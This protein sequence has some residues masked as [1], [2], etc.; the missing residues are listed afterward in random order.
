MKCISSG[1]QRK[2]D[3]GNECS[4][5]M[6]MRLYGKCKNGCTT[7]A[8]GKHGYC[9]RCRLRNNN[10]PSFRPIGLWINSENQRYCWSC[11]Q[12]KD[13]S[14][15]PISK[16]APHGYGGM[17]KDCLIKRNNGY[18]P[19]EV[20]AFSEKHVKQGVSCAKCLSKDRLEIDHIFPKS[21][22]GS[23]NISNLQ[24]LC[25]SCNRKKKNN[26]CVDYRIMI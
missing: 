14:L 7:P 12:I 26:E 19:I 17:C 6:R 1:C 16:T 24:I 3:R 15:F 4:Y 9:S 8:Q 13:I 18:S 22:G 11:K 21:L 5:H 23:D 20:F 25:R 2:P 10:S